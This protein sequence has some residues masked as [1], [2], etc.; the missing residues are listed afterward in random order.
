MIWWLLLNLYIYKQN[1][2]LLQKILTV[3]PVLKFLSAISYYLFLKQSPWITDENEFFSK[4]LIMTLV[5]ISSIFQSF[6]IGIIMVL[7]SGWSLLH[8]HMSRD[9]STRV[10][11][12]MG[13]TYLSY[14]AY[15]VSMPNSPFR[16]F[17]ECFITFMY[18]YIFI[19]CIKFAFKALWITER[20]IVYM[21]NSR[22]RSLVEVNNLKY[23]MLRN[24]LFISVLFFFGI[25]SFQGV[26][27]MI[28]EYFS[29]DCS[30]L[31][32]PP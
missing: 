1:V 20:L 12:S 8:F 5:T 29:H 28:L 16:I 15:Y 9:Y 31:Y 18:T 30:R 23:S 6:I 32:L 3:I 21:E 17:M 4:Y 2:T 25:I 7:S 10:T 13:I 22:V 11:V 24:Y 14:S 26:I 19:F 27:P